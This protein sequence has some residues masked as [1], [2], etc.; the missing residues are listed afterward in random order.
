MDFCL[1]QELSEMIRWNT[2]CVQLCLGR[3]GFWW[4]ITRKNIFNNWKLKKLY[5]KKKKKTVQVDTRRLVLCNRGL[6]AKWV[7]KSSSCVVKK[8]KRL[9]AEEKEDLLWTF[10]HYGLSPQSPNFLIKNISVTIAAQTVF[11]KIIR[12]KSWSPPLST[13]PPSR[14]FIFCFSM[15]WCQ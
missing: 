3:V 4:K 14:T 7:Y 11:W 15:F 2:R 10:L 13:L 1:H 5:N 8:E 9:F 12:S 6:P